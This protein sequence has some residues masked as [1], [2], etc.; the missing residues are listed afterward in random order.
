V[1]WQG[2]LLLNMGKTDCR[3]PQITVPKH[4]SPG[5]KSKEEIYNIILLY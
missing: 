2:F 5:N 3:K 1:Y 4:L